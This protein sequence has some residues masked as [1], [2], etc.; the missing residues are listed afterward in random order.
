MTEFVFIIQARTGSTRLANKMLLPF[1]N[2]LTIPQIIIRKLN[3]KFDYIPIIVA[4]TTNTKDDSLVDLLRNDPCTIVRG[5]E[6]NLVQRFLDVEKLHPNK[7]LIRVCADNPFLDISLLDELIQNW[8][9]DFD[10]L[11]HRI[12]GKP[13]MKTSYGFFA[14]ITKFAA[15]K[16][17]L[18]QTDSP[19]FLEHVTNYIYD[20]NDKFKVA[21]LEVDKV[22]SDNNY[23]R[24]TVDTSADFDN[25][26]NV[27][28]ALLN[29]KIEF[30]YNDVIDMVKN[31]NFISS[32]ITETEK[33]A[34]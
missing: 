23:I 34:K 28:K 10:Y 8:N 33:N 25:A 2:G 31:S 1:N 11:A 6:N 26:S 30:N 24:L 4:T 22:I 5:S 13:C 18:N 15:L 27:Y 19:L 20:N 3:A 16:E 14:E 7:T 9:E 12:N 21:W 29:N 32:M 17:V